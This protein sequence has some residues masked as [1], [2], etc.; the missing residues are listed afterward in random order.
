MDNLRDAFMVELS[1]RVID[2]DFRKLYNSA[3]DL[4]KK[5]SASFG[6]SVTTIDFFESIGYGLLTQKK[7]EKAYVVFRAGAEYCY[8]RVAQFNLG[9]M[10]ANGDGVESNMGAAYYWFLKA[11]KNTVEN[12]KAACDNI[13]RY[14]AENGNPI[15][16][17]LYG[18]KF[19][20]LPGYR[21]AM[22]IQMFISTLASL[23]ENGCDM[24]PQDTEMS[25]YLK[26]QC[27]NLMEQYK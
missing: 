2:R 14:V 10:F 5:F 11:Y 18:D 12:G 6:Q 8:S 25:V 23:C 15:S 20:P 9:N 26:E 19:T 24:F 27:G 13:L 17:I 4:I 3:E 16:N 1:E 22:N 7:F 21:S